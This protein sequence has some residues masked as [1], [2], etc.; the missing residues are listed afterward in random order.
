MARGVDSDGLN[1]EDE[2]GKGSM[3]QGFIA[4]EYVVVIENGKQDI[5]LGGGERNDLV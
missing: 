1:L 3:Q 2:Q 4:L 5:V